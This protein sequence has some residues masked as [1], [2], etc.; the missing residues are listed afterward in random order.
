[1]FF[2]T[3]NLSPV[4][5]LILGVGIILIA[6]ILAI[7]NKY[8]FLSDMLFGVGLGLELLAIIG[9]YQTYKNK[10]LQKSKLE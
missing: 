2:S 10:N 4:K 7:L 8:T 9:F 6:A 3:N 1:M 5:K